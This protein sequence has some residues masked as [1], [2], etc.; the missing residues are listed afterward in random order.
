MVGDFAG[1]HAL[2][3][4]GRYVAG[5]ALE[6]SAF[7]TSNV[8]FYLMGAGSF[9]RFGATVATLPRAYNAMIIRSVFRGPFGNRHPQRVAGYYSTQLL[10]PMDVFVEAIESGG[11][12][13]Y[14]DLVT[15]EAVDLRALQSGP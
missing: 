14:P 11:F 4:I 13:G 15:R 7:Y 5:R 9:D 1:D 12:Y 8:E 3:A 6:V 2:P 10:Q